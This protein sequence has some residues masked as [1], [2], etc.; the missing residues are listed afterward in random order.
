M[1]E[2]RQTQKLIGQGQLGRVKP[3]GVYV[4][5]SVTVVLTLCVTGVPLK[6][7]VV[8]ESHTLPPPVQSP[9][10]SAASPNQEVLL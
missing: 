6:N 7:G 4:C 1:K 3:K 8:K 10:Y 2:L 5:P 9:V